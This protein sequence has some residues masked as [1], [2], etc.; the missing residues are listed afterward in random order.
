MPDG[1]G[2]VK[3]GLLRVAAKGANPDESGF[4]DDAIDLVECCWHGFG[5]P[6]ASSGLPWLVRRKKQGLVQQLL[7]KFLG[8]RARLTSPWCACAR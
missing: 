5:K 1:T 4:E 7:E 8:V 3:N 2:I 6:W